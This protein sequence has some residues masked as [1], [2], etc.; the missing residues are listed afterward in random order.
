MPDTAG[1]WIM[2]KIF[3]G[4]S[5]LSSVPDW[6]YSQIIR[7]AGHEVVYNPINRQLV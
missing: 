1:E 4:P 3:I 7:S 2:A 5:P 6:E